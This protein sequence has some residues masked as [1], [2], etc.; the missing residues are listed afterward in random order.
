MFTQNGMETR[1]S[2]DGDA[3]VLYGVEIFMSFSFIWD[4]C[5][6][7]DIAGCRMTI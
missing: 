2:T 6:T 7:V 3:M 5:P 4:V 1:K